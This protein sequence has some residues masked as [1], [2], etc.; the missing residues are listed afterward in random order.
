MPVAHTGAQ[1]IFQETADVWEDRQDEVRSCMRHGLIAAGLGAGGSVDPAGPMQGDLAG[2]MPGVPAGPM[3]VKAVGPPLPKC[4]AGIWTKLVGSYTTR[5]VTADLGAALGPQFAG[6]NFDN[7]YRQATGAVMSGFDFGNS[8][9]TSPFDSIVFSVMGGYIESFLNFNNLAVSNS[10][11]SLTYYGGTV[12]GSATYMNRGFFV[13]A[14]LKADFLTL[15]I[16][17]IPGGF[18]TVGGFATCGR[19]VK[20]TTWGVVGNVGY[21]VELGRYFFE[22][23]GSI[24]WKAT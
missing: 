12:A 22:P 23:L 19:S 10:L 8:E 14:L 4:G 9:L 16:G 15:D 1:S 21:R 5:T 11:T 17:G 18:C 3:P 6:L 13:D 24:S 20:S 7:S 2:P